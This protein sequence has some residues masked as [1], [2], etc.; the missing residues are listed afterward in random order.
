[1]A[2]TTPLVPQLLFE[3]AVANRDEAGSLASEELCSC[4]AAVF[5]FFLEDVEE[6]VCC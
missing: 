6:P 3:D 4:D 5:E 1:M 2:A